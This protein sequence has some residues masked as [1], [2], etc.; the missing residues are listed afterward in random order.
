MYF[1][2]AF[3]LDMAILSLFCGLVLTGLSLSNM[4]FN[5]GKKTPLQIAGKLCNSEGFIEPSVIIV[6]D[7]LK[8]IKIPC[9]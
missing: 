3:K 1:K 6:D 5:S 2:K 8:I 7:D 9:K 4:Y